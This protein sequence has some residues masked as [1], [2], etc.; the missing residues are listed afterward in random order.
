MAL[1]DLN[2]RGGHA[3]MLLG[4]R[5]GPGL[6][7]ALENPDHVD[8]LL[9]DR[10]GIAIGDRLR[11]IA[12]EEAM[13]ADPAPT[14]AGVKQVI[15]LLRQRFNVIVVDMPM[16]P[17][18]A[19][20]EALLL[21]R[22]ALLVLNPE[23]ASLRDAQQMKRLI[24]SQIGGGRLITVLNRSNMSGGLSIDMVTEGLGWKPEVVIPDMPKVIVRAANLGKPAI[25]ECQP[26]RRALRSLTQ[27][28]SGADLR[29]SAAKLLK[30]FRRS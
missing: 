21:A 18:P 15:N 10:V 30:R 4:V 26:L 28:A 24:N 9:L 6:R 8:G 14:P 27:E 25:T 11:V 5:P 13:D 2:L 7:S 19:E 17:T 23:V 29:S 12:A 16:P 3:A 22:Q 1:L 20:R